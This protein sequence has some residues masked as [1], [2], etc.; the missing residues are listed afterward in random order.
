[1]K[2]DEQLGRILK[3]LDERDL[4]KDFNI[5]FSTDHGFVTY[6]GK[7]NITELLVRNGLKQNKESE[8]VVVAGG[9]IHVKEHDK[10]KIRKIVALLQA[11]DWIGSVFTRGATKK[12]TAGWVP[13]TLAFSAIHWD[14]AERSGDILADYNWNDEKNSTGYPGTSMGKGVAGHGSMSPYEVHIPL[15]ASG[16]DFI[17]ATESGLPTSNVDIT[18]T[19]LFLQGI[20]VPA[21]MAGRVLSELLTGSNVKNTEVKVQH[22]T[23]SVNLPSGTYNLDLQVSVL[24]KYRYID[25]SKVTRTSSTASAGN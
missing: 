6:A 21:S 24:G 8:D 5:L 11:Q 4:R 14:N 7:D 13:G 16:P 25:F 19:V 17:A 18:P 10:D 1:R 9:S 15:I 22:I 12:S 23:T 2:V 3:T 20:K